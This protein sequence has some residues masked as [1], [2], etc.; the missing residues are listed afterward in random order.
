MIDLH[1]HIL[2]GVDD[3]ADS[4]DTSVAMAWDAWRSGTRALV[5]TPHCAKPGERPNYYSR[6]LALGF[7]RLRKAVAQSGCGLK[8]Y[9]G[10]EI[11][12][13]EQFP[14]LLQSGKLMALGSSGYL[15]VE[16]YFDESPEYVHKTI[17]LIRDCGLR[18]V[19]AH[20]ER[21]YCV[22]WD[23]ALAVGWAESGAVLQ[24][25]RGSI[26]GHLGQSSMECAWELLQTGKPHVVA[27]D[28]HGCESR[29][30]ELKSVLTEL[31]EKLSWGYAAKLLMENP[32]RILL[33][34][35]VSG[36][37]GL[38]PVYKNGSEDY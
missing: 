25:N 35:P 15:L 9:S 17:R 28:A 33:N 4:M 5:A 37:E 2:P 16:F 21:Y 32:R 6:E 29:R 22:Q 1:C 23:P 36:D 26:Q 18:P 20:P 14:E 8:I 27:S 34:Q 12:V 38:P 10:M 7:Q 3:G 11:F 30:A 24:L 31:G 19:V 13:T